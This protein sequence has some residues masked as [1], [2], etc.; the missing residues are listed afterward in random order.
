MSRLALLLA[1][2][3]GLLGSARAETAGSECLPVEKIGCYYI[4]EGAPADAPLLVYLRGH[5]PSY[6]AN[7][8]AAQF[9]ASA[10]Q[11]FTA[12]G[13]RKTAEENR[14]GLLVTYRSDLAVTPAD[15]AAFSKAAKRTFP[16][17]I[18]AAHSGGYVGL[19]RS[20]DAGTSASRVLML[21][22][23]YGAGSDGLPQKLQRVISA[24]AGCAGFYTPHNKK[25]Y[26][27]GYLR[28]VSCSIE[29]MKDDGQHNAAV[30][31]CLGGY[32]NGGTCAL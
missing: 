9:L 4:P 26:E 5:H 31:R 22:N 17:T 15:L 30:V 28:A 14:T 27:T 7:V 10:R 25:N 1:A 6:A 32:L 24:G 23:F 12:Y 29:P 11:A 8:P 2:L 21:D 3:S 13:L 20:L 18:I 16:K 19:G